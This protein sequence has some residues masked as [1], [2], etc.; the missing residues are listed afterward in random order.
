MASISQLLDMVSLFTV[1][2]RGGGGGE[3]AYI[4]CGRASHI[5]LTP[6]K[7]IAVPAAS[8]PQL[9]DTVPPFTMD[10]NSEL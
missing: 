1:R 2:T 3:E 6:L 9:S 4:Y 7:F 8:I 10:H 5:V